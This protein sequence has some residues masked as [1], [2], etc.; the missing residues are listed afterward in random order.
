M[1]HVGAPI[2]QAKAKEAM[3]QAATLAENEKKASIELQEKVDKILSVVR[4]AQ[5]GDLTQEL[6]VTGA[7]AIGQLADGLRSFFATL[8]D[9][10]HNIGKMAVSLEEQSN[11]L[12]QKNYL[13]TDNSQNAAKN[14][15]SMKEKSVMVSANFKNLNHSTQE[16]KQ[17]VNEI[18]KQASESSRYSTDAVGFVSSVK[19][20][21]LKLEVNTEDISRFLQVINTIAR[22]TNLLALNAT[23]E[24]ARAGDAGK[25]FAVVANEVKELARQSG[26]A[27]N[28]ITK[29]VDTIKDNTTN[30]MDSIYK[31]SDLM[32]HLS[33]SSRFVASATEEQYATTE[34][35][36]E[37]ITNSVKD[38]EEIESGSNLISQTSDSSL[39]TV[40]EALHASKEVKSTST[41]FSKTV[42]KFKLNTPSGV[43][44]HSA[45]SEKDSEKDQTA[46]NPIKYIKFAS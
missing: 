11:V 32:D 43:V 34:Q 8:S 25:G 33:N 20:L 21:G 19:D 22:Q 27:A 9:D 38:V 26:D 39:E 2:E 30:I 45:E 36:F 1:S 4:S 7:D 12:D 15:K 41:N 10:L 44:S 23:I 5:K 17:A 40:K 6:N 18:S 37:L 46:N 14:S 31:V 3:T 24:A 16:L 28:E 42:S 35:F 29:K 13:M